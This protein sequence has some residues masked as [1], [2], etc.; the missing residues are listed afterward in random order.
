MSRRIPAVA[1]AVL[2]LSAV[3]GL[4]THLAAQTTTGTILGVVK[5]EQQAVV[6]GVAVT[7]RNVETN[8]A[9]AVLTDA[10][11]RFRAP[12]LPVGTYEVTFEL[13]GF[14]RLVRSGITLALNQD[15]VVEETLR[16]QALTETITVQ[17]D[18]PLLNTTNAEV[19]VRFD[20]RRVAD[21]PVINSRD[22]FS[23]ALSAPGVSQLSANQAGFA[24]GTNFATNGMR[25]R[26]NNFMID[27]Q[28]SNDPSITGR[29]QPINNTEIVQEIRLITNQFSAEYGRAAGSVMNVITKSGTNRLRGSAFWY[30]NQNEWNSLSNLEKAAGFTEAPDRNENQFGATLG[31]PLIKDKTF[32]FG[33]YQRWTDRRLG[34]GQTLNGAPTEAGRQVLQSAAGHLPQV[35]ALLE[36]LPAAQSPISRAAQFTIGGRTFTVPLGSLTGSTTQLLNNNQYSARLDHHFSADHTLT[37]RYLFNDQLLSGIGSQV[38]PS[39]LDS[40]SP[41]RQHAANVWLT[42]ILSPRAVNEFR[43]ALQRLDTA[44]DAVNPAA[45]EIPSIEISELGLLGFNAGPQRTA[46]GFGVNLPQ[47][48]KNSTWQIQETFSYIA[49]NH[50]FKVGADLRRVTVESDFNPTIRGLLF[51]PTLQRYVDDV[52]QTAN[53]N[54]PLPGGSR[55]V[56]YEWDDLYFFVQDE[57]K[58]RPNL[59]LNLGLRYELPGNAVD[60]LARLNEQIL[61]VAGGD[62]RFALTSKPKKDTDN[63]EP[64]FGF[65]WN[66][67]TSRGGLLGFFTG[68]DKLVIRGGYARTHDYQFLNLAL[69][70]A[71]S[72]PFVGAINLPSQ[73]VGGVTGIPNAFARLPGASVTGNPLLFTRTVVAEDF[74]APSADQFSFEFQRQM[75]ENFVLRVGYVGTRGHDLFQSLEGNPRQPFSTVRQDPTR[76]LIRLRANAAESV[77]HSLQV[78]GEQRISGGFSAGFH[79]TWSSFIDDGSDTFNTSTGEVATPQDPYDTKADRGRSS[80]DRPHRLAGNFVYELPV[81]RD[82]RAF[83]GKVFGGW[84]ISAAFAFQ[85][86]PPFTVF[87]GADPT[88]QH[89]G[90]LVGNP[91]RPNLNTNLDLSGMSIQEIKDA[92]GASLFKALCGNPSPTCPGERVGNVGRNTL[93]ADGIFN[94]DLAIIKNTRIAEGHN[95]QLRLEMFNATNSRNFGIPNSAINSANFLNEKGTDGGNRRI[96]LSARYSF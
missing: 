33:S 59:T 48:R 96:W 36:H 9:R 34:A 5:D 46:I 19:G 39:G 64:R 16:A 26:S 30:R 87:N 52:A 77:Y 11:G 40:V 8:V 44:T 37:A 38:T 78:S 90:S 66:P 57:W 83:A 56:N 75:A 82:Q 54:K 31:G 50:A 32:F 25:V 15:A 22:V 91:I 23:L 63:F 3:L 49:G 24:T 88:G 55:L 53:I 13:A 12:N 85:S 42:S 4:A 35:Q 14:G 71:S 2:A 93:R 18:A 72:F 89:S 27:G 41:S 70:V 62:Q 76:G 58:V 45:L 95:L 51:Y 86:G 7:V 84:Q 21:L 67:R 68:G 20:Q 28:D 29:Q 74:G 73:T 69:N 47:S 60:S 17:A 80:Y 81:L 10:G 1:T 65:N 6:P 43:V 94:I 61:D 92:G 79:Y